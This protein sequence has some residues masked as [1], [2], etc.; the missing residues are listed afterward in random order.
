MLPVLESTT[1][2]VVDEKKWRRIPSFSSSFSIHLTSHYIQ[3]KRRR[4][5]FR[6]SFSI[7]LT[8]LYSQPNHRRTIFRQSFSIIGQHHPIS[9]PKTNTYTIHLLSAIMS[10]TRSMLK[11][12]GA[13]SVNP[14]SKPHISKTYS[15]VLHSFRR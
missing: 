8:S 10:I 5:V 14:G 4:N 3:P 9:K 6:Q 1:S 2:S 13:Q 7:H 15:E 11:K 12:S